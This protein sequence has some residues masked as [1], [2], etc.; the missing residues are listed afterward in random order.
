MYPDLLLF[1]PIA[2]CPCVL[3]HGHEADSVF[4]GTVQCCC[5]FPQDLLSSWP[6]KPSSFSFFSHSKCS[7]PDHHGALPLNRLQFTNVSRVL[8]GQNLGKYSGSVLKCA[9]QRGIITSTVCG[10]SHTP[11]MPLATFADG[12]SFA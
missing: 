5:M 9:E 11:R 7:C 6:N 12:S 2:S 4:P 10:P 3:Y 1:Q 8:W